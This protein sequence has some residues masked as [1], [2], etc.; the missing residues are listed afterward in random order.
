[1]RL[2]DPEV[3]VT[4]PRDILPVEKAMLPVGVPEP[5]PG[6]TFAVNTTGVLSAGAVKEA[7]SVVVV[8]INA[9]G[10]FDP[11]LPFPPQPIVKKTELNTI[12]VSP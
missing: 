4:T 2:P 1:M 9:G 3:R 11:E 12:M 10:V 6:V 7:E 5:E 8:L